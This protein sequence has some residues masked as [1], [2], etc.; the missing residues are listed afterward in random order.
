MKK[1]KAVVLDLI[2]NALGWLN[3]YGDE[4]H[5]EL[6]EVITLN[7]DSPIPITDLPLYD[8]W[9]ILLVFENGVRKRVEDL[10]EKIG[11]PENRIIYPLDIRK[12][13][14]VTS[15]YIF[16]G[17][18]RKLIRYATCRFEGD[19]YAMGTVEGLTYVNVSSDNIIMTNMILNQENWAKDD[20][21]K[22]YALSKEYYSFTK[23]QVL[24]CDI[25]ANIGT[26]CIYFKKKIDT[27]VKILAFEPSLQNYRLLRTNA[28]LNELDDN[29]YTF[30]NKGLSDVTSRAVFEYD[31]ANPGASSVVSEDSGDHDTV[32]L[33]TL[34]DYFA[35]NGLD[36]KM[37][38]YLWVDVEGFEARFLAGA[39]E[40]LEI[41]NAP[42]IMEFTPRFFLQK[43]G[44]F[45]LL[46]TELARNFT[47]FI[48]MQDRDKKKK[49][50]DSLWEVRNNRNI[51]WDL[52][53]LK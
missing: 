38:K 20:M 1:I 6:C 47:G 15:S 51:Q 39:R 3:E 26:S 13:D 28:L 50:L 19:K 52:F 37:I 8:N 16:R 7:D 35:G 40:I 30:V 34:D 53:L 14:S 4:D 24:F 23:D 45:E 11:I 43:E 48:C 42:I 12:E 49:S 46:M 44:E 29:D 33:V 22:F 31:P 27:D 10:L 25:G 17:S 18:V 5:L 21:E 36:P 9:D 41:I 32:E 2:G